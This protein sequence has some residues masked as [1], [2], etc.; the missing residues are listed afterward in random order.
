MFYSSPF[1]H[2]LFDPLLTGLC[3]Q[4]R[5]QCAARARERL[6]SPLNTGHRAPIAWVF[7]WQPKV[8]SVSTSSFQFRR[9]IVVAEVQVHASALAGV[10]SNVFAGLLRLTL[11]PPIASQST[12]RRCHQDGTP[13]P[14][15]RT[16]HPECVAREPIWRIVTRRSSSM[17]GGLHADEPR[18]SVSVDAKWGWGH[19]GPHLVQEGSAVGVFENCGVNTGRASRGTPVL[20]AVHELSKAK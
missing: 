1:L 11:G 5:R 3:G 17:G 8:P 18:R 14:C 10:I 12:R 4:P 16:I 19:A 6:R 2:P 15:S 20:A 7:S 13:T 9:I